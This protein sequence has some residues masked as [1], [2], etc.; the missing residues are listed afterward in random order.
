MSHFPP[1]AAWRH[2]TS[3]PAWCLACFRACFLACSLALGG[4]AD[5]QPPAG[6]PRTT[7]RD[8]AGLTVIHNRTGGL[9]EARVAGDP[10]L[11]VGSL[12]D[13]DDALYDVAAVDRLSD[14]R[15]VLANAGT[16]EV[17]I[18][19]RDGAFEVGMGRP[20]EG[21]GEFQRLSGL[22]VLAGDS[23]LAWDRGQS[24]GIVFTPDG[25]IARTVTLPD[26]DAVRSGVVVGQLDSG[27]L[28]VDGPSR[29]SEDMPETGLVRPPET[30]ALL[31]PDGSEVRILGSLPG[32]EEYLEVGDGFI[33][34]RSV[35]FTKGAAVVGSGTRVWA[36][37]SE[38]AELMVWDAAGDTTAIWRLDHAAPAVTDEDW[39][40]AVE[41][42]LAPLDDPSAAAGIRQFYLDA[43][44]PDR[45]PAW[46]A[47]HRG[48]DG[49][50]WL[51]QFDPPGGAAVNRWWRL[52]ADGT[53][54][55]VVALPDRFGLRW[56]RADT[57]AGIQ[58]DELD[59]EYFR[60]YEIGADPGS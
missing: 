52:E 47:L 36:G 39:D 8:S 37:D 32:G 48:A 1:T 56:S 11:A 38:R 55:D 31:S 7:V 50:V 45:H 27:W 54:L 59:V 2:A 40:R 33:A 35:P 20:G 58:L 34:I 28:V 23:I 51:R 57:V 41:A 46:S 3:S 49:R 29:F 6:T 5:T 30:Y 12:D 14:G 9:V 44:R 43:P 4:C 16:R 26:A 22:V 60:V 42:R 15:W 25:Q 53:L 10:L 13:G 18:Y 19:G 24:R 17:R 21:P